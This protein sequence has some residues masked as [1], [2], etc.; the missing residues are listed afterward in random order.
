M[1]FYKVTGEGTPLIFIHG[2]GLDHAMWEFQVKPFERHYRVITYDMMGHGES[3][4]P[5]GPYTL[6]QFVA[7]LDELMKGL[8]IKAAH[9]VGFSMGGLVAQA[10]AAQHPDKA[11]SL[12]VVSSVAKRS[13]EQRNSVWVRVTEVE[14][15]GHTSTID[16]AILRWFDDRFISLHPES[17]QRIRQR[18]ENNDPSSYLA[19]YKV[20]ASADEEVY[21]LLARIRCPALILTGELDKGSTPQMAKLMA[22]CI[23]N[24][25]VVVIPHVRHMLPVESADEFNR[26]A[27]AFLKDI[28]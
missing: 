5:H 4:K 18:L 2:V 10:F 9:I 20:F 17:V 1:S 8:D 22:E 6:S 25:Q 14:T 11:A 15:M 21:E 24:S 13:E 19:A 7:Q 23:P 28:G 27:L 16:A 12:I 3:E 26:L